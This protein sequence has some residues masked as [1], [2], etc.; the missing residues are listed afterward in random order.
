MVTNNN[1]IYS[2][3]AVRRIFKVARDV[4]IKV[5]QFFK[6]IWVWIKGQRPTFIS[7]RV[8]LQHFV[9]W[10]RLQ[11][12]CLKVTK[13]MDEPN[14]FTVRNPA[15]DSAYIVRCYRTA[16]ACECEDYKNQSEFLP[17][18]SGRCCKHGYAVLSS[19]GFDS[20]K[21]YINSMQI[22]NK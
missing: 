10:R 22:L 12:K 20:L 6:V 17:V 9:D 16:L 14:A 18:N 15:R 7:K 4:H 2:V 8:F 11:G 5:K 13:R 1:L 21:S 19:L 3:S